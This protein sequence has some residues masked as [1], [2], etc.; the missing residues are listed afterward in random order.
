MKSLVMNMK[1]KALNHSTSISSDK[2][3][4]WSPNN[5]VHRHQVEELEC[6]ANGEIQGCFTDAGHFDAHNLS[7]A[8]T[9]F[10]SNLCG[11]EPGDDIVLVGSDDGE[12][13][14]TLK[15]KYSDR[16][17][18]ELSIDFS[19]KGGPPTLKGRFSHAKGRLTWEDG[20]F[21]SQIKEPPFT[22]KTKSSSLE[23]I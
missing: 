22:L 23:G 16:S 6:P 2:V 8:G 15:G 13:V 12:T 10:I 3:D 21:W 11:S 9:R 7:W 5:N 18:G 17:K 1:K 14:W 19:P 20:N 4:A